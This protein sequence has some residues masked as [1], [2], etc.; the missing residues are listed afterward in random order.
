[1]T[2]SQTGQTA[3]TAAIPSNAS[4]RAAASADSGSALELSATEGGA[5]TRTSASVPMVKGR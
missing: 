1:M 2:N 4:Q 5:A 3:A